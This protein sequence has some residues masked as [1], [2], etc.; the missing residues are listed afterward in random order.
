MTGKFIGTTAH[1]QVVA[2]LESRPG[3]FVPPVGIVHIDV[4]RLAVFIERSLAL[5]VEV[6]QPGDIAG[7]MHTVIRVS[8]LQESVQLVAVHHTY[9]IR[10]IRPAER[11]IEVDGRFAGFSFLGCNKYDTV[12]TARTVDSGSRGIFQYF[13]IFDVDRVN[14]IYIAF[15]HRLSI[16]YI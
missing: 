7:H 8:L 6:I 10:S 9:A 1:R 11:S 15:F 5:T 2:M 12:G 14:S 13:Y 4:G 3:G 16:D